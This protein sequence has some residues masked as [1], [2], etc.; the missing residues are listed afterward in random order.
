MLYKSYMIIS[1]SIPISIPI[2]VVFPSLESTRFRITRRQVIMKKVIFPE[3]M[4]NTKVASFA[5]LE[6]DASIEADVYC[7][8]RARILTS[9]QKCENS[10]DVKEIYGDQT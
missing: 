5:R 8:R 6:A 1:N 3:T 2:I 10:Y 7:I 4:R 9:G